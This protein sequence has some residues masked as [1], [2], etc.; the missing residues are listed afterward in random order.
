VAAHRR[1]ACLQNDLEAD[2]IEADPITARTTPVCV[3]RQFTM[4]V[5]NN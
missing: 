2:Q 1:H 3:P 4:G 5:S